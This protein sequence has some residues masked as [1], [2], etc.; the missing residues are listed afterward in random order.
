[1]H[2]CLYES[3]AAMHLCIRVCTPAGLRALIRTQS[4]WPTSGILF[5]GYVLGLSLGWSF[6]S[7]IL[8]QLGYVTL[9]TDPNP[10]HPTP[11]QPSVWDNELSGPFDKFLHPTQPD[12]NATG[13]NTGADYH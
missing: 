7:L 6:L 1:M 9:C 12:R 4:P 8:L 13:R 2:K 10:P 11:P 5:R 3:R